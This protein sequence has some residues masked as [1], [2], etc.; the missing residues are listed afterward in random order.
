MPHATHYPPQFSFLDDE[1]NE[2]LAILAGMKQ[3]PNGS[4]GEDTK[5]L[6][7][8]VL[9]KLRQHSHHEE[10]VMR[11]YGYPGYENHRTYHEHVHDTL[12][13][14][15]EYFE[16][17]RMNEARQEIAQHMEN[18]VNEE[19]FVDQLF[20]EFLAGRQPRG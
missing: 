10:S 20:M 13:F 16:N 12:R 11:E 14:I 6:T 8:K 9:A 2:L 18:K 5:L 4:S 1:H 19:F 3:P 17:G 15:I 7:R